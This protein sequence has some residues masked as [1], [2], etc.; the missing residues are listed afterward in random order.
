M[1]KWKNRRRNSFRR[2]TGKRGKVK[3]SI[4]IVCEGA[5]TEPLYFEAFRISSLR[6]QVIGTGRNTESLV[7]EAIKLYKSAKSDGIIYEQVW[8]VFDKDDFPNQNFNNAI[9]T[10]TQNGFNVAYSNEAFELWYLL[11]FQFMDSA[12]S[13][14]GYIQKLSPILGFKY[15]KNNRGMYDILESRQSEAIKNAERLQQGYNNLS[16]AQENPSTT[17]YQLVLELNKHT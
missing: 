3:P 1:S 17:V 11:H 15:E 13:R 4:L 8:C 7:D 16:P 14:K 2:P 9:L 6:V 5:K 10:A 12:I